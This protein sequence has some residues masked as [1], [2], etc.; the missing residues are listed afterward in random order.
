[1]KFSLFLLKGT[2]KNWCT[3]EGVTP[4]S[5][6]IAMTNVEYVHHIMSLQFRFQFRDREVALVCCI[7]TF[8]PQK[9]SEPVSM[10]RA[11]E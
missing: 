7:L 11:A 6:R 9:S 3:E 1:M 8:M 4:S 2:Y 5:G 10:Q